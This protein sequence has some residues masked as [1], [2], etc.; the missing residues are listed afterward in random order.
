MK[1][2]TIG[3]K[4]EWIHN[5][6]GYSL[7]L[8]LGFRVRAVTKFFFQLPLDLNEFDDIYIYI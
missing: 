5:V 3:E 4:I 1:F 8:G 6:K 2:N 7:W